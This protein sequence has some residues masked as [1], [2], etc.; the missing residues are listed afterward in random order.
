[1]LFVDDCLVPWFLPECLAGRD[2][3]GAPDILRAT[4][5][6]VCVAKRFIALFRLPN[7][8]VLFLFLI[9]AWSAQYYESRVVYFYILRLRHSYYLTHLPFI[10][11]VV[12]RVWPYSH[13][14]V[15]RNLSDI[16]SSFQDVRGGNYV[17]RE[18]M[19][20]KIKVWTELRPRT[21]EQISG[22]VR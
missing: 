19:I 8:Y 20:D 18:I 14:D 6:P 17:Q 7:M 9:C 1:M 11:E 2:R 5:D 22:K 15:G 4:S 3:T 13:I 12:F 16:I 21:A 10:S